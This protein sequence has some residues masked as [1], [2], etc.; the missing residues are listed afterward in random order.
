MQW[1]STRKGWNSIE[2]FKALS[3]E[4]LHSFHRILTSIWVRDEIPPDFRDAAIVTLFKNKGSKADCGN[5]RGIFLL[6]IA[7]KILARIMLNRLILLVAEKN[8]PESQYGFR[9]NRS[10]TDMIFTVR[11]VQEK[12]TEQSMC[13]YAVFIVLTKVFDTVNR[14]ALWVILRTLGCPAKF[15][16]LIRLLHHD[17]TGEVLSDGESSERFVI[18]NGVKQGCVLAPVLFNLYFTQVLLYAI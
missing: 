13:L 4:A 9:H 2:I 16:T 1:Q 15:A 10:T 3:N 14:E 7:G 18:S 8:L 11:Q 5:H 6:S 17:M 12:C